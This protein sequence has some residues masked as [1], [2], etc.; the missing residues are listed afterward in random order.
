MAELIERM[1]SRQQQYLRILESGPSGEADFEAVKYLVDKGYT[2]SKVQL[3]YDKASYLKPINVVWAGPNA[4]GLDYMDELMAGAAIINSEVL[5]DHKAK[6][7]PKQKPPVNNDNRPLIVIAT[8]L[9][10]LIL[11]EVIRHL[12]SS[13]F[14]VNIG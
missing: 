7:K 1:E 9:A 8:G 2:D 10:V 11:F 13:R 6:K 12:L 3:S 4:S 14:G 5:D